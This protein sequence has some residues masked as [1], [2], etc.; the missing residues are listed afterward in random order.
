MGIL[1]KLLIS[2]CSALGVL[3]LVMS[4]I[5]VGSVSTNNDR[6]VE[7]FGKRLT[8][9]NGKT[10]SILEEN[11]RLI[12]QE[13]EK[14]DTA[15]HEIILGLYDS[16][17]K[18]LNN[19]LANQ[20]FPMI[21]SFDFDSPEQV[22]EKLRSSNGAI[23]GVRYYTSENPG[24]HDTYSYGNMTVAGNSRLYQE[25]VRSDYAYLK[26]EMLVDMAGIKELERVDGII[27]SINSANAKLTTTLRE[28]GETAL[29]A[30]QSFA[31]K[32]G[33]EGL[34]R[35]TTSSTLMMLLALVLIS[36]VVAFFVRRF[37][38]QPI[39]RTVDM[40]QQM[41]QGEVDIR[42]N[43]QSADEVGKMACAMDSF[44]DSLQKKVVVARKI[45]EGDLTVQVALAS[46]RDQLGLALENMLEVLN[47]TMMQAQAT[48]E[49]VA[50][51]S[52]S[53]SA[54]SAEMSQGATEQAA[55][56][57]E[58]SSSIEEMTANIRQNADNARQT[59][60]IANKS[61]R[62]A[63]DGGQ[64]VA[65][66][67]KA[68]K[69]IAEKIVIIEEI[70]RQTNLLALNAAIEA[71]RAGEHGKGFAVVAAE[72][73]KLAERSQAAAAE[74]NA[75]SLSSVE[76]AERAGHLLENIVPGI[77]STAELV[78]EIAAAS[79]EQDA[80][81]GQISRAIQQLD[82]VIQQNAS[83]TEEMAS[84]SEELS[85][86]AEK[87]AEMVAFFRVKNQGRRV[88]SLSAGKSSG[89]RQIAVNAGFDPSD[90]EFAQ[91]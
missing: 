9:E 57:E 84:T 54:T 82:K 2:I 20:I 45:A 76:V 86:Q 51:G 83:A 12:E 18:T 60:T 28:N 78:Q 13:L 91:F 7:A 10:R 16:S 59:E 55:S 6:I 35:F 85:A 22:I 25:E 64:A 88:T 3:F 48:A 66:T 89:R 79:G 61:A 24:S 8:E 31:L 74:I 36:G 30:T 37:V 50:Q 44:A 33:E 1:Q 62:E 77:Q 17:F 26:L 70:A 21:E 38:T 81:A 40:I 19:A 80:G 4:L 14:A 75:V 52:R 65:Q 15:V 43:L 68:M 90:D 23:M 34:S 11:S 29:G 56:A 63:R 49:H 58:A 5:S 67:V 47:D 42:L 73:R 27:S 53:I 87:L 39:R 46:R 71:A 69:D 32:V 72:V 41:E